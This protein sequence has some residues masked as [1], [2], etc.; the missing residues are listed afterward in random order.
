MIVYNRKTS[1]IILLTN[2]R[3]PRDTDVFR[4]LNVFHRLKK[5]RAFDVIRNSGKTLHGVNIRFLPQRQHYVFPLDLST[6]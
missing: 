2:Q 4:K 6:R 1:S 3:I 5:F